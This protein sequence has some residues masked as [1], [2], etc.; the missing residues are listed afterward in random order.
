MT[1]FA[2]LRIEKVKSWTQLRARG[3]HNFRLAGHIPPNA[4]PERGIELL[5]G[6]RDV[7]ADVRARMAAAGL[8]PEQQRPGTVL[9][10]EVLMTASPEFFRP[11]R[12]HEAGTWDA[13]RFAAWRDAS[14]KFLRTQYGPNLVSC[15][16]HLD[17]C[18]PHLACT[19]SV[20][21]DSPRRRGP[22]VRLN[23][24]RWFDGAAKLSALQDAYAAAMAPLGLERGIKGS[25]ARHEDIRRRYST[26]K[27]EAEAAQRAAT[28]AALMLG[29]AAHARAEAE[30]ARAVAVAERER[31][32]AL[33]AGVEA[34]ADGQLVAATGDASRPTLRTAPALPPLERDALRRRLA[35]AWI[36]VWRFV[37][38]VAARV[39]TA[40]VAART[41][42]LVT[43]AAMR[44]RTGRSRERVLER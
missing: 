29:D 33:C 41:A 13:E 10:V 17:E 28:T 36:E 7:V 39:D 6:S 24:S 35:P 25:R 11:G 3:G 8:D 26:L 31:A 4:D 44:G 16:A 15:A 27:G 30:A 1:A 42:A 22:R 2:I 21:D 34:F 19:L 40:A 32:A 43:A 14:L 37:G 38:R 23:A 12:A 20:V 18:T 9:A 5:V